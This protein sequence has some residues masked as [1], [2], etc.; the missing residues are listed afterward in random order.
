MLADDRARGIVTDAVLASAIT[1][2]GA[3]PAEPAA[4][5]AH[6]SDVEQRVRRLSLPPPFA[7]LPPA[8]RG[9]LST[10]LYSVKP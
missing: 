4:E 2:V 1:L 7:H 6:P 5:A 3:S 9:P 8:D 10:A